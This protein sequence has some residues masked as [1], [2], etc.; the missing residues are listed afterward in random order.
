MSEGPL[1]FEHGLTLFHE[2]GAMA[3][4]SAFFKLDAP[5]K[6]AELTDFSFVLFDFPLQGTLGSLKA[7]ETNVEATKLRLSGCDPRAERWGFR[8]KRTRI[9]RETTRA[10]LNGVSFYVGRLPIFYFPYFTFRINPE[11]SG[12]SDNTRF[13]YRSDNG[14]IVSQPFRKPLQHGSFEF[15]PRLLTKNGGQITSVLNL[16]GFTTM[17]DWVP[18]DRQL[19]DFSNHSTIDANRWRV[20]ANLSES[21]QELNVNIDF[22]ETSDFAYQHDFEFD[23]LTEPSFATNNTASLNY[24]TRDWLVDLSAQRFNSTS[25][26]RLLAER[27]PELDIQWQPRWGVFH[28]KSHVNTA[29]YQDTTRGFDRLHFEQ[30]LTAEIKRPWGELT[31]GG[32]RAQTKF[33]FDGTANSNQTRD[34]DTTHAGAGIYFD[35]WTS[36][37]LLTLEPRLHYL[38]RSVSL[39][40][41]AIPFDKPRRTLHAGQ[42]FADP[43]ISGLDY[44]RDEDRLSAGFRFTAYPHS[45][46]RSVFQGSIARI[47]NFEDSVE[48][49]NTNHGLGLTVSLRNPEGFAFEHRQIHYNDVSISNEHSTLLVFE[50]THSKSLYTAFGKR[51]GDSIDQAELGFRWP[52]SPRWH[53]MGAAA[54][55]W[56]EDNITGAHLG[57]SY[58]GC[59]FRTTLLFQRTIDWD[60]MRDRYHVDLNNQVMLR[61]DLSG[62]GTIGE[63]RIE[64]LINRKRFGF[65]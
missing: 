16:H 9:N 1:E 7:D 39:I 27:A 23:S 62:L 19:N 59:C 13:D 8:I 28:S 53:V 35:R 6:T 30:H 46:S 12:I 49:S 10:T 29:S 50:P 63:K 47:T 38:K 17:V 52:L 5:N 44:L 36:N 41:A 40:S 45:N 2:R 54:F 43:R 22:T 51:E 20:K 11:R 31:L 18:D 3:I 57:L 4:E 24:A 34:T 33:Q 48:S 37:H 56:Q 58:F 25:E 21:W 15:T 64:T 32:A 55:D 14:L 61:F 26:E 42:L 65:H 60:F